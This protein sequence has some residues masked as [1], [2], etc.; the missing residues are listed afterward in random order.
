MDDKKTH[1]AHGH[2]NHFIGVRVVH[3]RAGLGDL[4]LVNVGLAWLDVRLV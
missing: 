1:H 4:P 2:L 3:E